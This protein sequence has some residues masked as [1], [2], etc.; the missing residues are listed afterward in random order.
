MSVISFTKFID[1]RNAETSNEVR[2]Y[3]KHFGVSLAKYTKSPKC[4]VHDSLC[5]V[6]A[7]WD[8]WVNLEVLTDYWLVSAMPAFKTEDGNIQLNFLSG[9]GEP[10]NGEYPPALQIEIEHITDGR[11]D[12]LIDS[13]RTFELALREHKPGVLV[14]SVL[15]IAVMRYANRDM[16]HMYRMHTVDND[17]ITLVTESPTERMTFRLD[18]ELTRKALQKLKLDCER[19][20][21]R[22][23]V[24][25]D[26]EAWTVFE[27]QRL[28]KED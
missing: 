28:D 7:G 18:I 22:D 13:A 2:K 17:Q 20:D 5:A 6:V 9:F 24:L 25:P 11:G 19:Q 15:A 16:G 12:P 3:L 26:P 23:G 1:E 27:D 21:R 10:V 14:V 8:L 4:K